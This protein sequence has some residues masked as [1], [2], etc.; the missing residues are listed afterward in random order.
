MASQSRKH[1]GYRSQKVV[2]RWFEEHGW[3][4][5]E[6]TGAGRAGVDVTGIPGLACEVKARAKLE[7]QAWLRQAD[8][9]EGLPFVVFR[10]NGVGEADVG[11]WGVMMRLDRF[12]DLLHEAGYGDSESLL[13]ERDDR[14]EE[15]PRE[16][17]DDPTG[18][19]YGDGF[20][21]RETVGLVAHVKNG[22]T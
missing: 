14:A 17:H 9:E 16:P 10:L 1:R 11:K 13:D 21:H 7:P 2:A 15:H 8:R 20:T 18:D 22:S 5:A 6:S 3:P 19:K 12:T 4:W